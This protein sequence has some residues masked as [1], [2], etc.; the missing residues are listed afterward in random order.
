VTN[1]F[2]NLLNRNNATT[3]PDDQRRNAAEN[4]LLRHTTM[5]A[6]INKVQPKK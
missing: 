2:K 5:Q 6:E 1:F 3:N 4:D